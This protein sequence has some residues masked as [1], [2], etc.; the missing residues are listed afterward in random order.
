MRCNEVTEPIETIYLGGGTP[1]ILPPTLFTKLVSC[2]PAPSQLREF[3]IEANPED[4]TKELVKTWVQH[5][6]GRVSMGI[7]SFDNAQLQSVGRRHTAEQAVNAVKTLRQCGINNISLDL[8]YGLPGQTLDSWQ[9]SLDKLLEIHPQHFSAY[10]LSYEP[11]TRL[12]AQL[13]IGKVFEADEDLIDDMYCYLCHAAKQA[14]YEHYEISNFAL[15]EHRAIHNA[16]Y[17]KFRQYVGLGP[18][19]HSFDGNVRR[20]NPSNI[21]TYINS[22]KSGR[23][24]AEMEAE[25]PVDKLHDRIMV[26]L[27]TS[28]GIDLSTFSASQAAALI[29]RTKLL[30]PNHVCINDS[31]IYIPE[32]KFLISDAIIRTL[33][34]D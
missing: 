26:G 19:A 1:S 2:L 32:D 31:R 30:P 13:S 27:R 10:I 17:W 4:I 3:T 28:D 12:Y 34:A 24:A 20:I 14:E 6:V 16:N 18:S 25:T 9:M 33:M 15:P 5:G 21:K 29:Q 22:I 23:L 11:G 8:I 7:Q